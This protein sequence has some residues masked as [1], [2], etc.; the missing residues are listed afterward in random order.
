M[1]AFLSLAWLAAGSGQEPIDPA[2]SAETLRSVAEV[3]ALRYEQAKAGPPVELEITV[4]SH[5]LAGFDGQ[6]ETG[7]LFFDSADPPPIGERV[8]VSGNVTGGMYGPYILVDEVRRLGPGHHPE[9]LPWLPEHLQSGAGDNRWVEVEG[10]LAEVRISRNGRWG[11]GTLVAGPA[12]IGVRFRNHD[13]PFD[14][15]GLRSL[16]GALVR[17][18]GSGAPLFNDARQRIG[19]EL[20]CSKLAFI[21]VVEPAARDALPLTPLA[22]IRSWDTRRAR[23]G[24]V[25][26]RGVVTWVEVDDESRLVIQDDG[27]GAP[28]RLRGEVPFAVGDAVEVTGLTESLGFFVGV[29]SAMLRPASEPLPTPDSV[30]DDEPVSRDRPFQLVTVAGT[31]VEKTERFLSVR[32]GEELVP[33]HLPAELSSEALPAAGSEVEVTGVKWIDADA[34]GRLR[35]MSLWMRSSQ[36]L[37]VL[38]TPPWWTPQRYLSA[39]VVLLAVILAALAWNVSLRHRVRRQ[40]AEI[41][42]QIEANATLE[43]RDRIAREL[44]DT[45]SQGFAG[46]GYQLGSVSNHLESDPPR[47]RDKLDTARRMVEHSLAEARHA[48]SGLRSPAIEHSS[49]VEAVEK[50]ATALGQ[51]AG[52]DVDLDLAPDAAGP[53]DRTEQHE[54][55]RILLEAVNNATRHSRGRRV[56][57][58]VGAQNGARLLATVRDDGDG[59]DPEMAKGLDGHFGIRGMLE[60][61]ERIRADLTVTSE[62]GRGAEWRLQLN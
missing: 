50:G 44:H 33:I 13:E 15:E 57:V 54:V 8:A 25:R 6:D 5:L 43:E 16:T 39:I 59:F 21:D 11:E 45:L 38:R 23:P 28:V 37:R 31:L 46:V 58:C 14:A 34:R 18:R 52:M 48:L 62:P 60:R 42:S 61:A 24:L 55:L 36:D 51:A 3:R 12:E 17:I 7:G 27:V 10:L 56:A 35:S 22:E 29:R 19:S 47:A 53:L 32:S 26:T 2:P 41:Q 49:F 30:M 20:I 4:I 1:S 40:T 9:P